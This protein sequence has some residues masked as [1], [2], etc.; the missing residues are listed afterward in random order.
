MMPEN[1]SMKLENSIATP[2]T[3]ELPALARNTVTP[4]ETLAAKV[5][6]YRWTICALLFFGTTMNYV[7]R[8]VLGLLAPELQTR[9]GW[10][11]V[12]YG[13]IVTAFQ[14][15]YALGLL[16][17]GR[18]IDL[19]GT[20]I[21]YAVSIGIWSL[22]A[23]AHA[24]ARTPLGF[25]AARFALGLGEAGNF[26]AAIKTVAE[27]FPRKERALATGIFNSGTNVGATIGPLLVLWVAS[28][29]GWQFAFISTG[30]LS[31]IP[32]IFWVRTYRR[33][34]EHPRLSAA[35]LRYILSDPSEPATH[36]PW[37]SLLPHRQTWA[38]LIGK[39]LTDPIWWFFLFWL[40]KFLNTNHGL[41]LTKLGPPLVVI[42]NAACVGSIGGGWLA[43]RFL[44]AG[45]TLNRARKSAMLICAL[46]IV[47]IVAAANVHS[48]WAAVALVSL[49]TAGHQGW[50]ANLFTFASDLFPRR[51]VA[52]VVG[53]G[54]FG[55]AVGG[56]FIA[57]F[58]GWVLQVTGSYVPMFV[59][60]GSVY[61]IA[62]AFIQLLTPRM[63]PAQLEVGEGA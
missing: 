19:I 5:G 62:L 41:A 37:T 20:R 6:H 11:E 51:A 12:Q 40:P 58:T 30:L 38:F 24:L 9:I 28:R 44:K 4:R 2:A 61:L 34:Q 1:L 31:F 35:E 36:I 56:M 48:L 59:I 42:Y 15:A 8:Q 7:D 50:S 45:W 46:A 29:Y 14:A 13:Y 49:A 25:G 32:I 17:M 39:L 10:N 54:G 53:I 63:E 3:P 47:P 52:S 27:W 18:L 55:G 23:A 21:G 43:A 57:A 26:P 16:L 33:P 60:A 22:A